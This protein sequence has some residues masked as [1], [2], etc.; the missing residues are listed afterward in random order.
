MPGLRGLFDGEATDGDGPVEFQVLMADAEGHK[1][2][3]D[4]LKVRLIR[5]RRDYY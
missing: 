3:A 4:N 5:E 2:A 1:L